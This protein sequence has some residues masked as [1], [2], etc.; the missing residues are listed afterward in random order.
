MCSL[1]YI[2]IIF[3]KCLINYISQVSKS[4]MHNVLQEEMTV[5]K[6]NYDIDLTNTAL[7]SLS[8][9]Y[10]IRIVKFFGDRFRTI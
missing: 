9:I 8:L 7:N 2:K 6:L 10:K 4:K 1:A 5:R 3:V